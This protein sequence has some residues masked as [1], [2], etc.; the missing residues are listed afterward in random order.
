[1]IT[2]LHAFLKSTVHIGK[3]AYLLQ[4]HAACLLADFLHY[5]SNQ[6]SSWCLLELVWPLVPLP[7]LLLYLHL[8]PSLLLSQ[9]CILLCKLCWRMLILVG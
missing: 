6:L 9:G 1:M 2:Y 5:G 7:A 4:K 3:R 8:P